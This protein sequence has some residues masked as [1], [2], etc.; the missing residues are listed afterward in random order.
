M[1]KGLE[2]G[3]EA[4]LWMVIFRA[5]LSSSTPVTCMSCIVR[6]QRQNIHQAQGLADWG[7]SVAHVER[8]QHFESAFVLKE[9]KSQRFKGADLTSAGLTREKGVNASMAGTPFHEDLGCHPLAQQENSNNLSFWETR[10]HNSKHLSLPGVLLDT[11][12]LLLLKRCV[13]WYILDDS[14]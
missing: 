14:P 2:C 5:R 6:R 1:G 8:H 13:L 3:L 7:V 10:G 12:S 11:I 9:A 4:G